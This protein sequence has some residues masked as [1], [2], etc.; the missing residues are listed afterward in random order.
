MK[1]SRSSRGIAALAV[2]LTLFALFFDIPAAAIAGG[3]LIVFLAARA[4]LFLSTLSST[5]RSLTAQRSLSALFAPQGVPVTVETNVQAT[6]PP[7]FSAEI[8]DLPPKRAV[9]SSGNPTVSLIKSVPGRLNYTLIL[10]TVGAHAFEGIRLSLSDQFFSGELVCRILETSDPSL[11]ILPSPEYP[12]PFESSYREKESSVIPPLTGPE[13]R[14]FRESLPGDDLRKID[15]KLSAKFGTLFVR[16]YMG[17]V[18]QGPLLIIDLPDSRHPFSLEA[19]SHLKEAVVSMVATQSPPRKGLSVLLICGP[20]LISFTPFEPDAR[21]LVDLIIKLAPTPRLH[22]M[23][24]YSSTASL[25]RRFAPLA[26]SV[27]PF[28]KNLIRISDAFLAHR[29][30]CAFESQMTRIFQFISA[31]TAHIFTL[32]IQD[33]SHIRVISKLAAYR[34]MDIQFHIPREDNGTGSKTLFNRSLAALVGGSLIG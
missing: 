19:F 18:E 29:P 1:F 34:A 13:V 14:S 31:S 23:F 11:I 6:V 28:S 24:R 5:A 21:R 7:G 20:N 22:S 32:D 15:W 30:P 17:R 9:L 16:E 27:D 4:F 8:S 26:G 12:F 25:K 2:V 3:A 33:A 10:N